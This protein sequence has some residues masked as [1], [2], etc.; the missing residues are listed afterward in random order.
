M[1]RGVWPGRRDEEMGGGGEVGNV[2]KGRRSVA[3]G[4]GGRERNS[5]R[6]EGKA[7]GSQGKRR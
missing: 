4:M 6:G 3:M 5:G 1:E 7:K 2:W